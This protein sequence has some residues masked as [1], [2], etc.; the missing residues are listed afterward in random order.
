VWKR[1]EPPLDRETVNALIER[2]MRIDAKLDEVLALLRED[3]D[4]EEEEEVD[5]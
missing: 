4:G 5:G 3:E 1:G 2:I